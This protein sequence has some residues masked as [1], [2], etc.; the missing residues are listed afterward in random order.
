MA[1][2]L[3]DYG[4][5]YP[6][7]LVRVIDGD[8]IIV[9]FRKDSPYKWRIRLIDCWAPETNKGTPAERARGLAAKKYAE[10]LLSHHLDTLS[11]YIPAP[12]SLDQIFHELLSFG[13]VMGIIYLNPDTTLNEQ[14]VA[15]GMA[16]KT[17][18]ERECK[19]REYEEE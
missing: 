10:K 9:K 1:R 13:R 17:R 15:A 4:L 7:W 6:V 19:Y 16:T 11:L 18:D 2:R 5:C 12:S 8:T 3:P 14:M